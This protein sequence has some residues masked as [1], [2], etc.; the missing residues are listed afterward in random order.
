VVGAPATHGVIL[1]FVRK[2]KATP[3]RLVVLGNG[4]QQKAYLHVS[5]LV[6]AMLFVRD[7]APDPITTINIGPFDEGIRVQ[8]IAEKVRDR[9]SPAAEI[10][11]GTEDRGWVGDI[12]IFRFSIE[13]LSRLGWSP[14]KNSHQ[15]VSK[16]IEEIAA[17]ERVDAAGCDPG[18]W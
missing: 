15:A 3:D 7:H 18:G 16:A 1:D 4:T 6:D 8:E 9:V 13:K 17:Q 5:D 12:P 10:C 2:L 14:P 11:Y